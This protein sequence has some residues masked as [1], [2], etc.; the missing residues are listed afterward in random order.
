MSDQ[1]A[2]GARARLDRR[3]VVR[4]GV[5]AAPA[6]AVVTTA[7]ALAAS[8]RSENLSFNTFG[9]DVLDDGAG[10]RNGLRTRVQVQNDYIAGGP[11]VNPVILRVTYPT[12]RVSGGT[13]TNLTGNGWSFS[14]PATNAGGL[15]TY[16]FTYTGVVAGGGNTGQLT[17]DLPLSSNA[18]GEFDVTFVATASAR[19]TRLATYKVTVPPSTP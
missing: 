18:P 5:W 14:G 17:Y 1:S 12:N 4:A 13:P 15:W 16:T 10:T 2:T 9:V 3:T 7:P 11:T 19:T 6:I 8:G